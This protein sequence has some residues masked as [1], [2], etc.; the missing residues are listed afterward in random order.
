MYATIC[1][2]PP[3]SIRWLQ[4][5]TQLNIDSR[6]GFREAAENV[7]PGSPSLSTLFLQIAGDR[8]AQARELQDMVA[9]NDEQPRRLGSVLGAVH[10]AWMNL[11]DALGGGEDMILAEAE[12]GEVHLRRMYEE[13]LRQLADC[14]CFDTLYNHH[15]ALKASHERICDLAAATP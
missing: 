1:H 14:E 7:L 12:R 5:L 4:D 6:D 11:R 8:A 2:L 15:I 13:A 9:R 10:R 3:A